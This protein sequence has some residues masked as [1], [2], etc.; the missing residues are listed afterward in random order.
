[1]SVNVN[2][3][4]MR[5]IAKQ[6][7]EDIGVNASLFYSYIEDNH[8]ISGGS[9]I[10]DNILND[11]KNSDG[12]RFLLTSNSSAKSTLIGSDLF[13]DT[14]SNLLSFREREFEILFE[15]LIEE[16]EELF[17]VDVQEL[18]R[19]LDLDIFY[20]IEITETINK[21][22]FNELLKQSKIFLKP[23]DLDNLF[24][25]FDIDENDEIDY[26]ELLIFIQ[27]IKNLKK[28]RER[29]KGNS[30]KNNYSVTDI[31]NI[32]TRFRNNYYGTLS[33]DFTYVLPE[34]QSDV[35]KI[36]IG[37]IEIP[38]TQYNVSSKLKNNSMVI[39]SDS[40]NITIN[41]DI[42]SSWEFK[43][44]IG[45]LS[46]DFL[47]GGFIFNDDKSSVSYD[48]STV[49]IPGT[50]EA[51]GALY[52]N[53]WWDGSAVQTTNTWDSSITPI[54]F[55]EF[56]T[57]QPHHTPND[58]SNVFGSS[59]R[60]KINYY[61]NINFR[62]FEGIPAPLPGLGNINNNDFK[63]I[64][65][66]TRLIPFSYHLKNTSHTVNIENIPY[67]I[68]NENLLIADTYNALYFR[69]GDPRKPNPL[70]TDEERFI[71]IDDNKPQTE[72]INYFPTTVLSRVE[73]HYPLDSSGNIIWG[74]SA[75][76]I[77]DPSKAQVS[78]TLD[79]SNTPISSETVHNRRFY[80]SE[81]KKHLD[82][83]SLHILENYYTN[84]PFTGGDFTS[85][86]S[87]SFIQKRFAS[88][89]DV[90][91]G[92]N[93]VTETSYTNISVLNYKKTTTINTVEVTNYNNLVHD[94]LVEAT[95]R[96]TE[97][98]QNNISKSFINAIDGLFNDSSG[99]GN[100]MR[101]EDII[102]PASDETTQ[103][104]IFK[105]L[106]KYTLYD[107]FSWDEH[108]YD[109]SLQKNNSVVETKHRI[110]NYFPHGSPNRT[111]IC[112]NNIKYVHNESIDYPFDSSNN[113]ETYKTTKII[114]DLHV[115]SYQYK[116]LQTGE[117]LT[118][119][120][121]I[122]F[123]WLVTL[124]DGNYDETWKS[125]KNI[126]SV[127][128][129]VND[130]ISIGIPGAIDMNGKFAAIIDPKW[131][132]WLNNYNNNNNIANFNGRL[133][134]RDPVKSSK[135]FS[136]NVIDIRDILFSIDRITGKSIFA[137]KTNIV[138]L[139]NTDYNLNSTIIKVDTF[140]QR[141]G[142]TSLRT[143]TAVEPDDIKGKSLLQYQ[144]LPLS[145]PSGKITPE[146]ALLLSKAKQPII[147][148]DLN[149]KNKKTI[150]SVRFNV[151]EYGNLDLES[152]I[153]L[154][155]GWV[156]GF[157]GAEYLVGDVNS[158]NNNLYHSNNGVPGA[159]GGGDNTY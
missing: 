24:K 110:N 99:G 46:G 136:T 97:L 38:M 66:S 70:I 154:K 67:D 139:D 141:V 91:F 44:P 86:M 25:S 69:P 20:K 140:T 126:S 79:S 153:Q 107:N 2:K 26:N 73:F 36:S 10:Y 71:D 16:F 23:N 83:S 121:P 3:D 137:S 12:N 90:S 87:N 152:N 135:V 48:T 145:E 125:S 156:L 35:K 151:D 113:I 112:W 65:L 148:E 150:T 118:S 62:D 93:E 104:H 57:K 50:I 98:S 29:E 129:L 95:P 39:I 127:E 77:D 124:P 42:S 28:K 89:N 60:N 41:K 82:P 100:G 88:N 49:T 119:F 59:N 61:S 155:L 40:N 80:N 81:F 92:S 47:H 111:D 138:N 96:I 120:D 9:E 149:Y 54:E 17:D 143:F 32:D 21:N 31:I 45:C 132:N 15:E 131:Y 51:S 43:S 130:S 128:K 74:W 159:E 84:T 55:I 37:S 33:T 133:F 4:E 101:E 72:E 146:I 134:D 109:I 114:D 105:P 115:K 58:T 68:P 158:N 122:K 13:T 85:D 106:T 19:D 14:T 7:G 147:V 64:Y 102:L 75:Q 22:E 117:D 108:N 116:D 123:A 5:D 27:Y 52:N 34:T 103:H 18:L 78:T 94:I 53:K 63:N 8:K 144:D 1:M 6:S 157:R 76:T 56:N 30:F 142:H 11:T